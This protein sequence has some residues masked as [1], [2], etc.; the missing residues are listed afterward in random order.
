MLNDLN[1]SINSNLSINSKESNK[2]KKV[3]KLKF[4]LIYIIEN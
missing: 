4:L 2:S 3:Y 1:Y